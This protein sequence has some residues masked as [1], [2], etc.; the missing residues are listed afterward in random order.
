MGWGYN[1]FQIRQNSNTNSCTKLYANQ[2]C[3]VDYNLIQ[4]LETDILGVLPE[5]LTTH[6]ESIFTDQSMLVGM[7]NRS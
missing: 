2:H 1:L 5:T 6:V 3:V 7:L 4:L